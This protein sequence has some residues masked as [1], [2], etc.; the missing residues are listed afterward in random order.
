MSAFLSLTFCPSFSKSIISCLLGS[1]DDMD[2]SPEVSPRPATDSTTNGSCSIEKTR[3]PSRPDQNVPQQSSSSGDQS[4]MWGQGECV[5]RKI[6]L[7][8]LLWQIF[9]DIL[10]EMFGF[11][12]V[13][14]MYCTH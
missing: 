14:V 8:R 2:I 5:C 7:S 1:G 10:C 4:S 13:N 6:L 9:F 3:Y 11:V 12:V